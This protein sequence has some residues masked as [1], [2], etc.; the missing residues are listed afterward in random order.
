MELARISAEDWIGVTGRC[1]ACGAPV[2]HYA[3][4]ADL[5]AKRPEAR[6]SDWWAACDNTA[7][8]NHCGEDVFQD[9]PDWEIPAS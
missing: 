2:S 7:C 4:N 1:A 9:T 8:A 5:I 3:C 6:D